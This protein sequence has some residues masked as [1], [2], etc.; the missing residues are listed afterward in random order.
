MSKRIL[1]KFILAIILLNLPT[2]LQLNLDETDNSGDIRK[3]GS[4]WNIS[5][6]ALLIIAEILCFSRISLKNMDWLGKLTISA[7]T[8]ASLLQAA[9]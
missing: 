5:L 8:F 9:T 6:T 4:I 1:S 3:I 2:T 7:Y